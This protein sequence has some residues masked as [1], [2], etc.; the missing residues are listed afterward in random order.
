[1]GVA[2]LHDAAEAYLPDV[3]RPIKPILRNFKALER[4]IMIT[5]LSKFNLPA[6]CWPEVKEAD[7][8]MLYTEAQQLMGD[9]SDWED[10]YAPPYNI[11]IKPWPWQKA[12]KK[13]LERYR[14]IIE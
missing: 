4:E 6:L 2:L 10:D 11:Q 13:F 1:L 14:Q 9:V 8:R 12:E 7:N 3:P 5:I